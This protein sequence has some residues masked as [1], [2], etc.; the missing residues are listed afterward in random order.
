MKNNLLKNAVDRILEVEFDG[1]KV[2][3]KLVFFPEVDVGVERAM[4]NCL[5]WFNR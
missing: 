4:P 3:D 2:D 1:L 5:F